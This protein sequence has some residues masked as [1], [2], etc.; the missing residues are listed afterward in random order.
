M[1]VQKTEQGY[2]ETGHECPY[3]CNNGKIFIPGRGLVP[4]P[5]CEGIQGYEKRMDDTDPNNFFD[6]LKIPKI[7]RTC[8]GNSALQYIDDV[9]KVMK[10]TGAITDQYCYVLSEILS[11]L[12]F[13][14]LYKCSVLIRE[15]PSA[16]L[17]LNRFV[18]GTMF[19]A[20]TK[21]VGVLPYISLSWLT[22]LRYNNDFDT[23]KFSS[24][25]LMKYSIEGV[26]GM[27]TPLML[28]CKYAY[29][30]DYYDYCIAPLV[31]VDVSTVATPAELSVL[32]GLI[33]ERAKHD[34]PTYVTVNP[35]SGGMF[36]KDL[37]TGLFDNMLTISNYRL[38][39]LMPVDYFLS[40]KDNNREAINTILNNVEKNN[41]NVGDNPTGI[42][43][44]GINVI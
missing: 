39:R 6:T 41:L 28:R 19:K 21:G 36:I 16:K 18:Y 38:D 32:Q 29:G 7:Y 1:N 42:R 35:R 9:S 22:T 44:T 34:L 13:G 27:S 8:D 17:D 31:F 25:P 26:T 43:A 11:A 14:A 10:A 23:K 37:S 2:R 12:E 15:L 3:H 4:C 33:T 5:E 30:I 24:T 20:V 40:D